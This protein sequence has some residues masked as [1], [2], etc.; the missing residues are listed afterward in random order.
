M[1]QHF[2]NFKKT[3]HTL[4]FPERVIPSSNSIHYSKWFKMISAGFI[5]YSSYCYFKRIKPPLHVRLLKNLFSWTLKKNNKNNKICNTNANI[6]LQ[7]KEIPEYAKYDG[8]W[9][10]NLDEMKKSASDN[11]VS[12]ASMAMEPIREN[13]PRGEIVMFYDA[14]TK[15]FIYYSNSKNIPYS[16]LD[17]VAR[18]YVCLHKVPSIYIDIRDEIK[19]GHDKNIKKEQ[20]YKSELEDNKSASSSSSSLSV[21]K[22][23]FAVFKN[24]KT[25]SGSSAAAAATA[26]ATS[27]HDK[28]LNNTKNIKKNET[29]KEIILKDNINKFI[30][31]G[32]VEEYDTDLKFKQLKSQQEHSNTNSH[33][34]IHDSKLILDNLDLVSNASRENEDKNISYADFKNKN[35]IN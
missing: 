2:L 34:Y 26:A 25:R 22:S 12:A 29:D 30:Y 1:S 11:F 19:K 6:E 8:G 10:A 7:V 27:L 17:A 14:Q 28:T 33:I 18:K 32:P 23:L 15:S 4:S 13:T 31:K 3:F 24:Y 9:Y 20:K 16:T 5:I 35:K 21:K